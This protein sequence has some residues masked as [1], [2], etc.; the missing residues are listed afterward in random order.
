MGI[1][2]AF[3]LAE[4]DAVD[5]AGV[6]EGIADDRIALIQQ[7]FEEAGVGVEARAVENGV[8]GAEELA[9]GPLQGL[10]EVLGAAD[11]SDGGH[12]VSVAGQ[13]FPCGLDEGR[14]VG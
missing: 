11:E 7:G 6:V 4:S 8:A 10:V 13:A 14:M 12:A 2:Q 3:G 5:K 9:Q 1:A